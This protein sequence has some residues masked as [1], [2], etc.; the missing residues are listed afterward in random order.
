[1]DEMDASDAIPARPPAS[2]PAGLIVA[3]G[4]SRRFGSDKARHS[5]DGTPM[6]L[7]VYRALSE[8]AK[9]VVV[10]VGTD[11]KSYADILP[12]AVPHMRDRR[13]NAGPMAG[14]DA[15][16]RS[17]DAPWIVVAACDMPNA[18][19]SGFQGL[20]EARSPDVNAVIGRAEGRLHPLFA[21][22]RRSPT[23]DAIEACW[24]TETFAL[25]ALLDRLRIRAVDVAPRWVHNVNRKR[26]V[27]GE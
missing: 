8:I 24:E 13:S 6:I 16:F 20:L 9:P 1:M 5:V 22:Y 4:N 11:A 12:D 10:S 17:V 21:V 27:P 7:R 15:G 3:G 2:P 25:F 26:D 19:S 18:T 23:L 14:L